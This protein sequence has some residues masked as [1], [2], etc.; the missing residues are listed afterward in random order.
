MSNLTKEADGA[1]RN[2]LFSFSDLD[3]L[4]RGTSKYQKP[5]N[6]LRRA[7]VKAISL[8]RK[9]GADDQ[10]SLGVSFSFKEVMESQDGGSDSSGI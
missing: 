8:G 1:S 7:L 6:I 4:D 5:P 9:K 10:D 3:L 2:D